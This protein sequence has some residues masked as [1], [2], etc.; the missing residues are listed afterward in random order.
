MIYNWFK[1]FNLTEFEALDLVS[2]NYHLDLEGLGEKDILVTKGNGV[3]IL[4]EGIFLTVNLNAKNPFPFEG[5]AVYIKENNDVYL[6]I[7]VEE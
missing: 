6:G 4:Y 7:E 5:H 3:S 2:K 1:I